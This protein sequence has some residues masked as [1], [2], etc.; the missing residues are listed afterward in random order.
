M[1]KTTYTT[2]RRTVRVPADIFDFIKSNPSAITADDFETFETFAK[3]GK[4]MA[5]L[6]MSDKLQ[7]L[8][9]QPRNKTTH[10]NLSPNVT[11]DDVVA[12]YAVALVLFDDGDDINKKAM[13][14]QL[15]GI[16]TNTA[17]HV[18][19]EAE[20]LKTAKKQ[21]VHHHRKTRKTK[22]AL[23]NSSMTITSQTAKKQ[24]VHHHHKT[25]K[26]KTALANSS[27]TITSQ[28]EAHLKAAAFVVATVKDVAQRATVLKAA[29][30]R[31]AEMSARVPSLREKLEAAGIREDDGKYSRNAQI[32]VP[33]ELKEQLTTQQRLQALTV[34]Y[35]ENKDLIDNGGV[36]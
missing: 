26:T 4:V 33:T 19:K 21:T 25:R 14:Q 31:F 9:T 15:G 20:K 12:A 23:A 30:G 18:R 13:T 27:M 34:L 36:V 2:T 32:T 16:I 5:A 17:E 1:T 28:Y 29:A 24:T 11:N 10:L 35:F 22:T 6:E 7:E 8:T 3:F